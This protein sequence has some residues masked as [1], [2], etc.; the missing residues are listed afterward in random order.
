ERT[1]LV[2]RQC[3]DRSTAGLRGRPAP[4]LLPEAADRFVS[5][6]SSAIAS[7]NTDESVTTMWCTVG[8]CLESFVLTWHGGCLRLAPP[9][10]ERPADDGH[11]Q[12]LGRRSGPGERG[13]PHVGLALR[14][15]G[16]EQT[17]VGRERE[18]LLEIGGLLHLLELARLQVHYVAGLPSGEH[19]TAL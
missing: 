14:L 19:E 3:L 16:V 15:Y 6:R 5:T 8:L 4:E 10:S 9:P 11:A 7:T 17:P 18:L 2:H 1:A 12:G 13:H